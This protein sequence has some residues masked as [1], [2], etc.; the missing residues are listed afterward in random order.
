MADIRIH[1]YVVDPADVEEFL[2][3]RAA[4]VTAV[5]ADHPGLVEARLVRL[6][7]GAFVDT[8]RW[9]AA[10]HMAAALAAAPFPDAGPAWALTRDAGSE[11]GQIIDDR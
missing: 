6:D 2:A 10:D 5:R 11:D 1:R 4:L 9:D 8:W 3:R 7:D